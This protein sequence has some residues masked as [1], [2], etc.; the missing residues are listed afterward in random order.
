MITPL[1]SDLT[2]CDL[3]PITR[4]ERIQS[5]GFLLAMTAEWKVVSVSAN[6]D[7]YFGVDAVTALGMTLD[8][9]VNREA[10]H[11][12]RNRITGLSST[13]GTERMYGVNLIESRPRVDIAIHYAGH[14]WI[15]EGEAA[16][17]DSQ[18][19]AASL[20]RSTMARLSKQATLETF[21][22]DAARQIRAMTGFDRVMIYRFAPD[23][24]GEVI[25]EIAKTGTESF[26]GLHY[27]ASDIPKQ[28]RA[29]YLRNPFRIIADVDDT[30]VALISS[31]AMAGKP[32]DLSLAITRA[33]SPVHLEY[34][35]NMG[36][37]ASLSVSI[38]ID[39]SL[40][41]LIACHH[42]QPRLPSFTIR[43]A[44][45]LFGQM[46]SM[47][48]EGRLRNIEDQEDRRSR[49]SVTRL[50]A[51]IAGDN[52]LLTHA[53]WLQEI[54]C[55]V[56]ACDGLS[57]CFAGRRSSSGLTPSSSQIDAIAHKIDF[58]PG[59]DI[60]ATE[61]IRALVPESTAANERVAGVLYI[62]IT[63]T[64]GDYIMLFREEK[65]HD[66]KW[67]GEPVKVE[68]QGDAI[69]KLSP[70]KSFAVFTESVRGRSQP[71]TPLELRMAETI[72]SGLEQ[73]FL[74]GS[75]N[76][77]LD[78]RRAGERQELLIAELNHRVR[79]VL[80]LIRGLISQTN[81]EGG[82]AAS[83]VKSLNGRVQALAR[84]HDRVTR[85]N[86]GPGPLNSIFDDEIAAY[87]PTQ[88][89]R[90]TIHGPQILLQP[91]AFSTL[92][93]IIHELV[94][95]SAKYGSL[96]EN[97]RVEVKLDRVAAKGLF[98]QWRELDGPAVQVPTRRGFGSVIIE[99]VVPFDLQGTALVQFLP[100]GIEADF[101]I[102]ERHIAPGEGSG[103][104]LSETLA[105][106]PSM[107]V[108]APSHAQ[109]LQDATVLLLE[110]N[111]I[112]ALEAEEILRAL[113]ATAVYTAS[114]IAGAAKFLA[115]ERFDFAVLDI[116]LGFETSLDFAARLNTAQ[117]PYVFA[118]GYGDNIDLG[119]VHSTI[120]TVAKPYD[121]DQLKVAITAT[122]ARPRSAH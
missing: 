52:E 39:G 7:I 91:Q 5:F 55:T 45:E 35:R 67:A 94:T 26:L 16:R 61:S 121:R 12:I 95:N 27:P 65:A 14:L 40:W 18:A 87:V 19:D 8:A 24:A 49:E 120:L 50:L 29:L 3:E 85:Q 11:D 20:V 80:A 68:S 106:D 82:D 113:G 122:L 102:P 90:F 41:G 72:R 54:L 78:R 63:Q 86:W 53:S 108:V 46:Y 37:A 116:N 101:F 97:G 28:A 31:P 10:L 30:V 34:L 115:A 58:T 9:F 118:S 89:N 93:L 23:G 100:A 77:E 62:P 44:A 69:P 119:G 76:A 2:L 109:P 59:A 56:V 47:T 88:R 33:V 25:A 6:L 42:S 114:T 32:I 83:Y 64:P 103:L 4:P 92:A 71:F 21:H 75:R 22:R 110:D 79:N 111:L 38:I 70:R 43:T 17:L 60:S 66:I 84:A 74:R 48:L 57:L 96:S 73:V 51:S 112:V 1:T 15:L 36:V 107:A 13:G 117:I 104:D 81:G 105:A 99:R 98:M